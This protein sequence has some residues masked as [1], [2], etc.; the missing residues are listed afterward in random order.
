MKKV[1]KV[2]LNIIASIILCVIFLVLVITIVLSLPVVQKFIA[3]EFSEIASNFTDT[4]VEIKA[5]RIDEFSRV[6]IDDFYVEGFLQDTIIYI[7]KLSMRIDT[8][9]LI[10]G[11]LEI[12]EA[13]IEDVKFHLTYIGSRKST[14]DK[15]TNHLKLKSNK[16]DSVESDFKMAIKN[17]EITNGEFKLYNDRLSREILPH[18]INYN[19]MLLYDIN[20]NCERL[21]IIGKDIFMDLRNLSCVAKSGAIL[22]TLHTSRFAITE[23]TLDFQDV[24]IYGENT[25][26]FLP[27]LNISGEYWEL[28]KEFDNSVTISGEVVDSKLDFRALSQFVSIPKDYDIVLENLNA[29]YDGILDNFVCSITDTNY[30]QDTELSITVGIKGVEDFENANIDVTGLNIKTSPNEIHAIFNAFTKNKLSTQ[31]ASYIDKTGWVQIEGACSGKLDSLVAKIDVSTE[32]GQLSID[33]GF[34]PSKK[35]KNGVYYGGVVG[36]VKL[37]LGKLLGVEKLGEVSAV[38]DAQVDMFEKNYAVSGE[39]VVDELYFNSYNYKDISVKGTFLDKVLSAHVFSKDKNL[40]FTLDGKCDLSQTEPQYNLS[41]NLDGADLHTLNL[42]KNQKVSWLS[43]N[44]DID[45]EGGSLDKLNARA[46][47][48]NLVYISPSDTLSTELINI[49][50]TSTQNNRYMSL[51][52]ALANIEYRG[53]SN[54]TDVF[55]FFKEDVIGKLPRISKKGGIVGSVDSLENIPIGE[56]INLHSTEYSTLTF[57][58]RDHQNLIPI[59]VKGLNVSPETS[60]SLIFNPEINKYALDINSGYIEWNDFLASNISIESKTVG[61]ANQVMVEIDELYAEN[62]VIPKIGVDLSLQSDLIEGFVTFSELGKPFSGRLGFDAVLEQNNKGQASINANFRDSSYLSVGGE[63]WEVISDGIEYGVENIAIN[64]F[65]IRN[66][67]QSILINGSASKL[68]SDLLDVKI[69]NVQLAPL[70]TLLMPN[71]KMI[72]GTIEGYAT[73]NALLGEISCMGEF[74]LVDVLMGDVKV[75]PLQFNVDIDLSKDKAYMSIKNAALKTTLAEGNFHPK[76]KTYTAKISVN[77]MQLSLLNSVMAGVINGSS[78]NA[79]IDLEINGKGDILDIN[80][81]VNITDF[82]TTVDATSVTYRFEPLQM[83]F[84]NNIGKISSTNISDKNDNLAQLEMDINLHDLSNIVYDIKIT[85]NN[86][87]VIDNTFEESSSFY[88][89][90]F[91]SGG[92]NVRGNSMGTDIDVVLSTD[93]NSLFCLP[94][95]GNTEFAA[96]ADFV[97]FVEDKTVELQDTT[98]VLV[99]KKLSLERKQKKSRIAPDVNISAMLNVGTNTELKLIIDPATNNILSARGRADLN[100]TVNPSKNEFLIRGDYEIA[101]GVYDFNFQNIINKR[102]VIRE[103]SYIQWTGDPSDAMI[104]VSAVYELKTSLAPLIDNIDEDGAG[105]GTRSSTPVEC[106]VTLSDK[107][108]AISLNFDVEVPTANQEYQNIISA[109]FSSD[110]MMATQFFYLLTIGSFYDDEQSAEVSDIGTAGTAIG[111]DFLSTQMSRLLTTDEY[112]LDFNYRQK[113]DFQSDAVGVDF[114]RELISDRL[115]LELEANYDTGNNPTSEDANRI[116]GGGTLTLML[117]DDGD[118]MFKGFSRTI[119]RFDENQGLQESGL[120]V[121]YRQD[122]N[123]FKDLFTPKEKRKREREERKKKRE[124]E[125]KDK[126]ESSDSKKGE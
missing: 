7:P 9:A 52:S 83:V 100:I 115:I 16:P 60:L 92:I 71:S 25:Q 62:V 68:T 44:L 12:A 116:S 47:I 50:A 37:D 81:N 70:A 89:T 32:L 24:E 84:N 31:I 77:Q 5:I 108:S 118:F 86:L 15:I 59:L 97:E 87:L 124:K 51:H 22:D 110:E 88:G 10:K 17:I 99:R 117:D 94:L 49:V 1:G 36:A 69:E 11:K 107:L 55:K 40:M 102:F 4:R 80:G 18:A 76:A 41:L 30:D 21:D 56:D 45:G 98:N 48:N 66:D 79:A 29:T 42:N 90:L 46:M 65:Y 8:E 85:P 2:L 93:D 26:L 103:G 14:F 58:L 13:R 72:D 75:E 120:G 95:S 123:K 105:A 28:Y 121:Y 67:N 20:T 96:S 112:R 126:E 19:D 119:D 38:V 113:S 125:K 106:I 23:G 53:K 63:K 91:V 43:G 74:N 122:F 6:I 27:N 35:I 64:N 78:G 73:L 39:V 33:G 3:K 57:D 54:Y 104:D 114:E 61:R 82:M 111:L 34:S 109:A 101:S